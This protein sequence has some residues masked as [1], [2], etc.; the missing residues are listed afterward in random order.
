MGDAKISLRW[1]MPQRGPPS[2]TGTQ[3]EGETGGL[4]KGRSMKSAVVTPVPGNPE[5]WRASTTAPEPVSELWRHHG[6]ALMRFAC[7]LTLGDRQRAEDIV[8]ETLLRA[9]RHPEVLGTGRAPI[10][11][12]LFTVA[13][14]VAIDVWRGPAPPQESVGGREPHT[15]HPAGCIARALT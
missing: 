11:P 10:R 15:P 8:Q 7:K 5:A 1:A 13:R 4:A 2:Q 9:W 12:W 6:S 3:G 14:R